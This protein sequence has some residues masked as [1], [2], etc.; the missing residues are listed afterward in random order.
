[1]VIK[2][3]Y[4][5]NIAY[6]VTIFTYKKILAVCLIPSNINQIKLSFLYD[7]NIFVFDPGQCPSNYPVRSLRIILLESVKHMY[8]KFLNVKVKSIKNINVIKPSYGS[9]QISRRSFYQLGVFALVL[10]GILFFDTP[11]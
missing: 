11:G 9:E 1:M 4:M 8:W 6:L 2:F 5:H 7:A 10:N 3:M